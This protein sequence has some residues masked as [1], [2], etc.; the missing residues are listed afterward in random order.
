MLAAFHFIIF[1]N[2]P[3]FIKLQLIQFFLIPLDE[4][5]LLLCFSSVLNSRK[6]ICTPCISWSD[7]SSMI[8]QQNFLVFWKNTKKIRIYKIKPAVF[9]IIN[10]DNTPILIKE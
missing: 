4:L 8:W 6:K 2:T 10:F 9:Y 5:L 3:A 1:L 7:L